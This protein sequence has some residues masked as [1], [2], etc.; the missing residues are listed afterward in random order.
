MAVVVITG[1]AGLIGSE[2]ARFFAEQ[3]LRRRRHRQRHAPL[4]LRRGRLAPRGAAQARAATC[5]AIATSTPTSATRDAMDRAV[6]RPRPVDC[7]G[8][9]RRGAA[10]ARL[11]G[12][13]ADHRLHGQRQRHAGPA[14]G[15]PAALP[16]RA[17]SSSRAPTRCTA[18]R[19]TGCRWS[20]CETRWAVD[21]APF[22]PPRHRRVDEHRRPHAQPVR[23]VQGGG[24]PAWCRSTGA[25]SGCRTACFRGGC[26]TGPGHSGARAA[27]L[28]V[29]SGEVRA[30]RAGPIRCSATRASRSATT[31][32]PHDLVQRVLALLQRAAR[33]ARSTTSAADRR[34]TARCSRRSPWSSG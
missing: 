6:R 18:T 4:L 25:T 16:R 12:A 28:P 20:S 15:D 33:R 27:R 11:G 1:A 21:R 26:L 32:I 5:A 34:R 17:R 10:L 14:G 9:P 24:R 31:S 29:V 2:A 3:G 23:R 7:A 8:D 19:R 30:S 22:R 13:G